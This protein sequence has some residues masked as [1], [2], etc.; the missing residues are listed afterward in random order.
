[1]WPPGGGGPAGGRE[2]RQAKPEG[3]PRHAG[4]YKGKI[5]KPNIKD[6][7][8]SAFS[9]CRAFCM[10]I[11]GRTLVHRPTSAVSLISYE[12]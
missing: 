6:I 2:D 4:D 9:N 1:V 3:T 12:E 5:L 10:R 8:L 11:C 7:M